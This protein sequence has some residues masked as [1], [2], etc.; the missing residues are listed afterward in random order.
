MRKKFI[1][2]SLALCLTLSGCGGNVVL[3]RSYSV[4]TPHSEVYWENEGADTLRADSYQDLVNA[5]LLLLGEH[6]EEGVVRIYSE[7]DAAAMADETAARIIAE[8]RPSVELSDEVKAEFKRII[9][10]AE[11]E[12]SE[13]PEVLE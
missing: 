10:D 3:E 9:A 7:E 12:V 4:S 8:H 6:S 1:P 13:H 11:A 2:L 5:L